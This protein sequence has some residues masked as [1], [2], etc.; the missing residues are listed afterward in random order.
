[1]FQWNADYAVGIRQVD[2]EHQQLFMLAERLHRA[3]LEGNGK[4]ILVNLLSRLVDYTCY[5]FVHEE[6]LMERI[7]Y[8]GYRQHQQEHKDLRSRVREMQDRTAS[9]EVT[10]TIDVAQFLMEWVKHHIIASDR[11]I[12]NYM[13][14]RDT[15]PDPSHP[16][17]TPGRRRFSS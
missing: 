11:R 16:T 5:H 10:M 9:G 4:A 12:G 13:T 17:M 6:Q 8:P 14:T 3:M 7:H 15:R 1:M 2:Q